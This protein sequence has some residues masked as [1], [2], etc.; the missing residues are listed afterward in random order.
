[1]IKDQI[2]IQK[3]EHDYTIGVQMCSKNGRW[4]S[5]IFALLKDKNQDVLDDVIEA[6]SYNYSEEKIISQNVERIACSRMF[7]I[8]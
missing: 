2:L 8:N 3:P 5:S 1:M 7:S 4:D 6:W